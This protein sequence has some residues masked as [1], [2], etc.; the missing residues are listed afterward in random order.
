MSVSITAE[1]AKSYYLKGIE[2]YVPESP[3]GETFRQRSL[4]EAH[5]IGTDDPIGRKAFAHEGAEIEAIRRRTDMTIEEI[6]DLGPAGIPIRLY[7]E[8]HRIASRYERM[9][10][11][12]T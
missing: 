11:D 4:T 2:G 7:D 3:W 10:G 12:Q 5:L 6:V 9:F 8:C 1:Q